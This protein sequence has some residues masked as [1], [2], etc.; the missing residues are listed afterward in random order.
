MMT[1]RKQRDKSEKRQKA[2]RLIDSV[3]NIETYKRETETEKEE[4]E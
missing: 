1:G 4:K 2:K 3:I